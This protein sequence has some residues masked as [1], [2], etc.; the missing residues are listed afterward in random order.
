MTRLALYRSCGAGKFKAAVLRALAASRR[1][2]ELEARR[3]KKRRE[4]AHAAMMEHQGFIQVKDPA[5]DK[6]CVEYGLTAELAEAKYR[7][8]AGCVRT[9]I[10]FSCSSQLV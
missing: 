9:A 1:E 2:Q 3:G 7:C 5:L 6:V 8:V 10:V 4:S